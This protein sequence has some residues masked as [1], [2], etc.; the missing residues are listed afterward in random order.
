LEHFHSSSWSI[1]IRPVG[2]F[3]FVQLEHFRSSSWSFFVRP[4][5]AFL[6]DELSLMQQKIKKNRQNV[7]NFRFYYYLCREK[8]DLWVKS[9]NFASQKQTIN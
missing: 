7:F 5:G 6:I 1:F 2:A 9:F 8:R 3:S 4:V